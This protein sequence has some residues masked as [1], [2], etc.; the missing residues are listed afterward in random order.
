MMKSTLVK[1]LEAVEASLGVGAV[2]YGVIWDWFDDS[3]EEIDDKYARWENGEDVPGAPK[4]IVNRK[5]AKVHIIVGLSPDHVAS[6]PRCQAK[7]QD[8]S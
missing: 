3:H 5:N 4:H 6:C 1:R 8:K 7:Q 2:E